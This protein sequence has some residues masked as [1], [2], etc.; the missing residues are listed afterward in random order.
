VQL[1]MV[2]DRLVLMVVVVVMMGHGWPSPTDR[3]LPW[4]LLTR[5]LL[6]LRRRFQGRA[7]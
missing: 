4:S 3:M 7:E 2:Y 6:L 5:S 1:V